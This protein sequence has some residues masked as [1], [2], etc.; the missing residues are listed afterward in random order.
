MGERVSLV[1]LVRWKEAYSLNAR[2]VPPCPCEANPLGK[3][4][5]EPSGLGSWVAIPVATST[6]PKT[7]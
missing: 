7:V 5:P 1:S 2:K 4:N 3:V 6:V